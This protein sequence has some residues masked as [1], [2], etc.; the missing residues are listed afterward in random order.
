MEKCRYSHYRLQ[1]AKFVRG[2]NA[3]IRKTVDLFGG[4]LYCPK[5]AKIFSRQQ[6]S[7]FLAYRRDIKENFWNMP[8]KRI[9][10]SGG[11]NVQS[12]QTATAPLR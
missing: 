2:S 5:T 9:F 7:W 4:E 12:C 8:E 10:P 1:V 11:T 6:L 3:S